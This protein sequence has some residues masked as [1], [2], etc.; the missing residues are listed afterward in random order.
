[1]QNAEMYFAP[2]LEDLCIRWQ[3]PPRTAAALFVALANG[4]PDL[5]AI[6]H[7][8]KAGMTLCVVHGLDL[9]PPVALY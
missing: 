4:A 8:F 7:M 3:V 9:H 5:A 2:A 1:V 6:A